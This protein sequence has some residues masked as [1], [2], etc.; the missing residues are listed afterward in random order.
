MNAVNYAEADPVEPN[1]HCVGLPYPRACR[2]VFNSATEGEFTVSLGLTNDSISVEMCYGDGNEYFGIGFG[3]D[4]M[5]YTTGIDD[6]DAATVYDYV[7][8]TARLLMVLL[9]IQQIILKILYLI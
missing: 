3:S 9:K 2:T 5:F 8:A 1:P 7:F 6:T 4:A